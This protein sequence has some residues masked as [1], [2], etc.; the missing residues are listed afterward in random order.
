MGEL[1]LR[2]FFNLKYLFCLIL[3]SN[4]KPVNKVIS[5]ASLN[6][7]AREMFE[8]KQNY[9]NRTK[10]WTRETCLNRSKCD[11]SYLKRGRSCS[12][13]LIRGKSDDID[14][15]DGFEGRT[16]Y[17]TFKGPT[18]VLATKQQVQ[19]DFHILKKKLETFWLNCFSEMFSLH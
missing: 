19:P 11:E 16:S 17:P 14:G 6:R 15:P 10:C 8:I 7:F 4:R 1:Q 12:G 5:E 9:F 3:F 2:A 13:C 18:S